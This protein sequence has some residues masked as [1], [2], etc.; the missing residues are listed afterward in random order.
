MIDW[1]LLWE[2]MANRLEYRGRSIRSLAQELKVSASTLTR[3][4]QGKPIQAEAFC[5]LLD[6]LEI[7]HRM[8]MKREGI[9][10]EN[11]ELRVQAEI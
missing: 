4:K 9:A 1:V 11:K 3:M 8:V 6:W 5:A 10:H 7:T 2:M